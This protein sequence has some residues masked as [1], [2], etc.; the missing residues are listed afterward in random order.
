MGELR[1]RAGTALTRS[2]PKGWL[3][4][5]TGKLPRSDGLALLPRRLTSPSL[6]RHHASPQPRTVPGRWARLTQ[7]MAYGQGR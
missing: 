2:A 6:M 3:G 7:V 4:D 5:W 1:L